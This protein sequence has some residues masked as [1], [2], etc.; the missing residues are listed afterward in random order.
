MAKK[1][2]RLQKQTR[3]VDSMGVHPTGLN[4]QTVPE[5]EPP[6][7][8]SW[9]S[10]SDLP[11]ETWGTGRQEPRRPN[12]SHGK[13]SDEHGFIP[14]S[15]GEEHRSSPSTGL[16][17]DTDDFG[18]SSARQAAILHCIGQGTCKCTPGPDLRRPMWIFVIRQRGVQGESPGVTTPRCGALCRFGGR[19]REQGV[20]AD[21]RARVL[22]REAATRVGVF[23]GVETL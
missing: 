20:N 17:L 14:T 16:P 6:S 5:G 3:W 9:T 8:R 21:G 10:G 18:G 1:L 2:G 7:R 19:W 22:P 12:H 23:P 11:T 4:L 13:G 15:R